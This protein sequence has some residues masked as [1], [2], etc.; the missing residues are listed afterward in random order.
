MLQSATVATPQ[1]LLELAQ[2]LRDPDTN[3]RS[4]Y[5]H[6]FEEHCSTED[7]LNSGHRIPYWLALMELHSEG[8]RYGV[9]S[10]HMLPYVFEQVFDLLMTS[11]L[12]R[13]APAS[14]E[15]MICVPDDLAR[16]RMENPVFRHKIAAHDLVSYAVKNPAQHLAFI[17]NDDIYQG[18]LMASKSLL[19]TQTA[20]AIAVDFFEFVQLYELTDAMTSMSSRQIQVLALFVGHLLRQP[21]K[22]LHISERLDLLR[23]KS[24]YVPADMIESPQVP[25]CRTS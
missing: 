19:P 7:Y 16:A 1:N 14:L 9:E 23:K 22:R 5:G 17:A 6:A 4:P 15:E 24:P 20:D 3:K 11:R 21:P 12:A 18:G 2:M 10:E 8:Y 25:Q 13:P